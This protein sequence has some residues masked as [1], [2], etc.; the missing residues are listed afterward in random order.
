[1]PLLNFNFLWTLATFTGFLLSLLLI[2][3]G[4]KPDIGLLE[5]AMGGFIIALPQGFLLKEPIACIRWILSS[6]LGWSLIT[7]IGIGGLGWFVFSTQVVPLRIFYGTIYGGL[8]GLGIGLTQWLATSKPASVG[9]RWIFVSSASWAIAIP[10][11][12]TVGIFL[13]QFTH[14]FLGEVIGLA[15]TWLLVGMFTGINAHKL[16]S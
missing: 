6:L 7:A 13:H 1:M 14:L 2:E 15:I 11:G 8:G 10:F 16:R 9:W 4:E 12:S 5:A 3:I